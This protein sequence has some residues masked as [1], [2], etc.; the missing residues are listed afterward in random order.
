MHGTDKHMGGR[1][2]QRDKE[3]MI[4]LQQFLQHLFIKLAEVDNPYFTSEISH[5]FNNLIRSRLS[6]CK[7]ILIRIDSG[8]QADEGIDCKGIVLCGYGTEPLGRLP[9]CIALL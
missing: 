6:Q 5:I 1:L 7:L 4:F 3:Q 8:D 2:K 9:V